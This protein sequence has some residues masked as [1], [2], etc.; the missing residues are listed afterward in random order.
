MKQGAYIFLPTACLDSIA[1]CIGFVCLEL[2]GELFRP[3]QRA[4][5]CLSQYIIP[6]SLFPQRAT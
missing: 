5:L 2:V 4:R 3:G 1:E 6:G